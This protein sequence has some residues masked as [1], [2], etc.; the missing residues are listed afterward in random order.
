[1][2]RSAPRIGAI[3]AP[4]GAQGAQAPRGAWVIAKCLIIL[5]LRQ[6]PIVLGATSYT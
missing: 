2:L 3:Q 1:V 5:G 4:G 6:D